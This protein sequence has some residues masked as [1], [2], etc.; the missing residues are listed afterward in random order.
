M[1]RVVAL[2]LVSLLIAGNVFAAPKI[3]FKISS[4]TG[5][6][7]TFYCHFKVLRWSCSYGGKCTQFWGDWSP[8]YHPGDTYKRSNGGDPTFAVVAVIAS[9]FDGNKQSKIQPTQHICYSNFNNP[10]DVDVTITLEGN[11]VLFN[12]SVPT[13]GSCAV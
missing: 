9:C 11:Q 3:Q 10:V 4:T 12:G 13:P 7:S 5:F 2:L 6:P 1:C 8:R